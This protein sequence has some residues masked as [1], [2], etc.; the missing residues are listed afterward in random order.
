MRAMTELERSLENAIKSSRTGERGLSPQ[1][2]SIRNRPRKLIF[3]QT[4]NGMIAVG[5]ATSMPTGPHVRPSWLLA[6]ILRKQRHHNLY[7]AQK[8][9]GVGP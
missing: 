2:A 5:G 7:Q 1:S 3:Y 6:S 4:P 8:V 9:E